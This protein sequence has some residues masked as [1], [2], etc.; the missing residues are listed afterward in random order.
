MAFSPIAA[1]T[2]LTCWGW[3]R[4]CTKHLWK[5]GLFCNQKKGKYFWNILTFFST[6]L[7]TQKFK[8]K[9]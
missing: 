4:V 1:L 2:S 8:K 9:S 3:G 6:S 5:G 7:M